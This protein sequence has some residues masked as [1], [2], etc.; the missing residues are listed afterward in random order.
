MR[1]LLPALLL[2][3]L[4]LPPLPARAEGV[5]VKSEAAVDVTGKDAADAKAQAMAKGQIDALLELLAKLTPP[6]QAQAIVD[7]LDGKKI[8]KLVHGIE[9]SEEK[10]SSDRYRA[11]LVV[12]FDADEIGSLINDFNAG[13]ARQE[14]A[15]LTGSFIIIPA[16]QDE[17]GSM[18]WSDANPWLKTWRMVG[19]EVTAGDIIVPYGDSRDSGLLNEK[20]V[21]SATY[22]SL[23]AM[24]QRYGASDIVIV[25]AKFTPSPDMAITVT[26]RRMTRLRNEVNTQTYRADPQETRDELLVRAARDI[27]Y[28]L[29]NKKSEELST[30]QNVR[31]G[32]RHTVMTL[33]SL[34]TLSSWTH[35]RSKLSG[36]PMVD[37]LEL[38]AM[39]P[40]QVDMVIHYRGSPESLAAGIESQKLRL[41]KNNDYW[42]VS[43]D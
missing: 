20:G 38:L 33:A 40:Q 19:L 43:N 10:I 26:K 14:V 11:R 18:L 22:S 2:A 8:A 17:T 13:V 37:R 24:A 31:G 32:E 21:D 7:T 41:L 35:I 15:L 28:T 4:M 23:S 3:A 25:D 6:G 36:L 12:S 42:V 9:V 39:S 1:H 27:T 29:Q 30:A 34:T 16:F 5:L